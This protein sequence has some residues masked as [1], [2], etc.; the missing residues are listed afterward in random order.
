M[1]KAPA[2]AS[3]IV[4]GPTIASTREE[5]ISYLRGRNRSP[6]TIATYLR[7]LDSLDAFLASRGMPRTLRAI[8]REHLE[9]WI[10]ELQ[11]RGLAAS[12]V[13]ILFRAV[14][15]FFKYMVD[16]DE[17][18]RSPMER[19]ATPR[20]EYDPPN[21]LS[22]DDV[23]RLLATCRGTDFIARRDLALVSLA[24][25]SGV[26]RGE[27]AGLNLGDLMVPQRLAYIKATTSK[28]RRGRAVVFGDNTAKALLRYLR[29]PKAPSRPDDALWR[30]RTGLPLTGNEIYHTLRRRAAQAGLKVHP[31]Q[32]R[33]TWADSM[34]RSGHNEGDVMQLGGWASRQ[35]LDRYGSAVAA[36]RARAAYRSPIDRLAHK[37]DA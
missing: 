4:E 5:W 11:D 16:E 3:I 19:M 13:S 2:E 21:V 23:N 8:R 14:R 29:H 26:R 37:Q 24:L 36:E 31:H 12:H 35:M 30:A 9:A 25:D 6:R 32:L 22:P 7:G 10:V 18:D 34:L 1:P 28:S 27:L 20:V 15:P 33:H 17:L